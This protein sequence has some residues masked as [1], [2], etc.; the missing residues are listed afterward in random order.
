MVTL[1]SIIDDP[2]EPQSAICGN[3]V[4]EEGE[5][6]DCGWEEDCNDPCCHPQRL[7]HVPHEIP[8]RLADG[9]VCSPSQVS[10]PSHMLHLLT[11]EK[12]SFRRWTIIICVFFEP[13]FYFLSHISYIHSLFSLCMY[14]CVSTKN[15]CSNIF[16]NSLL[17]FLAYT[18][19]WIKSRTLDPITFEKEK[20][21][22]REGGG[23][24]KKKWIEIKIERSFK[25]GLTEKLLRCKIS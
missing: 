2:T 16:E 3:G 12:R 21:K 25:L 9:A 4:V 14:V 1:L 17:N 5:E 20:G 22:K 7:H 24:E 13:L 18:C 6:C 15:H 19:N 11:L 23:R 8:C 10:N